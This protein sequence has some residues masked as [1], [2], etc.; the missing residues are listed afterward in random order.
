M[1]NELM[2]TELQPLLTKANELVISSEIEYNHAAD[3]LKAIKNLGKKVK[4]TFDPIC[5]KANAAH[6]EATGKRKEHQQPLKDAEK[7]IKEKMLEFSGANEVQKVDGISATSKW[8]A[9]VVD[10]SKVPR[11]YMIPDTKTLDG[12]AK[13]SKNLIKIPGVEFIETKNMNVRA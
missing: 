7:I 12:I 5:E 11:K 2:K 13:A 10:I 8:V 1:Q 3:M 4:E 6:K 9:N